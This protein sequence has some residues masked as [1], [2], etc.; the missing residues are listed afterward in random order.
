MLEISRI[1]KLGSFLLYKPQNLIKSRLQAT[2]HKKH[3]VF[4]KKKGKVY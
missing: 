4:I 3:F 1:P 2:N